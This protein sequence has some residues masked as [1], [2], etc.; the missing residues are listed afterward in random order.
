MENEEFLGLYLKD[1]IIKN[2]APTFRNTLKKIKP[3][4]M[5]MNAC[6]L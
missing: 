1:I 2:L 5:L 6:V 4:S 3:K